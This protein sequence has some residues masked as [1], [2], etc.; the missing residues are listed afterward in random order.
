M[1]TPGYL[2]FF[3]MP[4][5]VAGCTDDYNLEKSVF[6]KDR[7]FVDLPAYSEWGYNTF[8]AYYGNEV[9]VSDDYTIPARIRVTDN[10]MAFIL[11]GHKGP[12]GNYPGNAEMAMTF[13]LNGYSPDH[14]Q[15]LTV[16]NDS[17]IDLTN[18]EWQVL[19]S[20]GNTEYTADMLSGELHFKRV[21]HLLV[22]ESPMEVI[23]SGY[24]EF[25]ASI[26]GNPVSVTQG[27]FDV[28]IDGGNFLRQ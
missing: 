20:A 8:G 13:L 18:P 21:Q 9:F 25:Q 2:L 3:F 16:F 17:V 26:N 1:K 22:D 27:R 7:Q 24:F 5:I 10:S 14:Y 23:L 6:I 19:I 11:T 28:G 15:D 4:A 12:T